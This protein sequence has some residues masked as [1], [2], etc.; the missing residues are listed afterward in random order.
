MKS[1]WRGL[2]LTGLAGGLVLG[3][4]GQQAGATDAKPD[5]AEIEGIVFERQN[6]MMQLDRDGKL[7][8]EIV[9]GIGPKEKLADVTRS[10]A[11][12]AKDSLE[13]YR[14]VAPGG[15][16]KAEAWTNH[17]DFLKRMEDFARNAEAMAKVGET[18]NV[19]AV[20]ELLIDAMPCKQCHDVYRE[21][22]R[23]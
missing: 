17:A 10:I 8:G 6:T 1:F 7:L 23:S 19:G 9:A 3:A 14:T 18:G 4:S 20:T 5:A 11:Q 22:K 2:A 12:G 21:P 13:I 15:H 16:T